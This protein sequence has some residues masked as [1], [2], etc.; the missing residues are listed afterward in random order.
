MILEKLIAELKGLNQDAVI[1]NGFGE[2]DSYRGYYEDLAF[3]PMDNVT[4][5]SMLEHAQK[6]LG[7]TY[8]GYKGGEFYMSGSTDCWIARYGHTG[9]EINSTIINLWK[10]GLGLGRSDLEIKI[11]RLEDSIR[12]E[13]YEERCDSLKDS[14]KYIDDIYAGKHD[15]YFRKTIKE[16]MEAYK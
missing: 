5:K 7:S 14:Q 6:A 12:A 8:T 3:E 11:K 2:A 1:A 13:A 15:E 16:C 9:D 10:D 4:V